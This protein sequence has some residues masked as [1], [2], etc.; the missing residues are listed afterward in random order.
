MNITIKAILYLYL[1]VVALVAYFTSLPVANIQGRYVRAE[2]FFALIL[3][4]PVFYLVVKKKQDKT[5]F[6]AFIIFFALIF[7]EVVVTATSYLNETKTTLGFLHLA[8]SIMY[9][10]LGLYFY[11]SLRCYGYKVV[12]IGLTIGLVINLMWVLYQLLSGDLQGFYG[13][14]AFGYRGASAASGALFYFM[15]VF[16]FFAYILYSKKKFALF[17]VASLFMLA[18]V[19]NRTFFIASFMMVFLYYFFCIFRLLSKFRLSTY[20]IYFSFFLLLFVT[21]LV[22]LDVGFDRFSGLFERLSRIDQGLVIRYNKFF[23]L[24]DFYT[25][26]ITI[27]FGNGRGFYEYTAGTSLLSIDSQVARLLIESGFIGLISWLLLMAILVWS[28]LKNS[29]VSYKIR[30]LVVSFVFSFFAS[31]L[32]YDV[33]VISKS[34]YGFWLVYFFL[35]YEIGRLKRVGGSFA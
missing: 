9:F 25:D 18:L 31:M 22:V 11:F 19:E 32:V 8:K 4:I 2:D 24:I 15:S 5:I 29:A 13:V 16:S 30:F 33:L 17:T 7:Y 26:P 1:P 3:I 14:S 10:S 23:N 34:G 20:W 27:F 6:T 28:T 12:I 35:L 21:M